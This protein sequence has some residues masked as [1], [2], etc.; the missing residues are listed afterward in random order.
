MFVFQNKLQS[1]ISHLSSLNGAEG[2]SHLASASSH[3]PLRSFAHLAPPDIPS[4][5]GGSFTATIS[6]PGLNTPVPSYPFPH[7]HAPH[8]PS[9]L[10]LST[11]ASVAV[12]ASLSKSKNSENADETHYG[13]Q[14]SS[15][16]PDSHHQPAVPL[17]IRSIRFGQ[18][19]VDTWYD[20]PFPEEYNNIPE[21][22]LWMCEFCLRY[23]KSGFGWERHQTKCR[24]RHPPGD[25][26]YR[27]GTISVF[28][29]DGRRNKVC[30]S[31]LCSYFTV[32]PN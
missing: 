25:E 23:M 29:V 16:F 17:R 27:D 10:S 4:T 24:A 30:G 1:Q 2:S 3:R 9:S 28:E 32:D 14:P 11:L 13:K 12:A 8:V 18:W 5:P 20:A 15:L 7:A 21:G 19:D 31:I 6:T 22:R 26:I